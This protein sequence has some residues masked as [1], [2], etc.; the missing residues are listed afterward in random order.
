MIHESAGYTV[1]RYNQSSDLEV[2]LRVQVA[3]VDMTARKATCVA[4]T[5]YSSEL[6]FSHM[7]NQE[8]LFTP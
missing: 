6:V 8:T 1:G 5:T 7:T 4:T 3:S 2:R